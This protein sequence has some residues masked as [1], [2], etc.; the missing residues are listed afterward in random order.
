MN[1]FK[2]I[3]AY[4][5]VISISFTL[6]S[7]CKSKN[8]DEKSTTNST[9]TTQ[10][11]TSI[12]HATDYTYTPII[13][14]TE[15]NTTK[16]VHTVPPVPTYEEK[17]EKKTNNYPIQTNNKTDTTENKTPT[18]EKIEDLNK[19]LSL[20]TKTTPVK[21]GNSATIIIQGTP[22]AKYSIEFYKNSAETAEYQ[23]LDEIKA[24]STGF[25]SWTF[26]I[27]N[28]C[29]IGNRK[30]IIKEK[31]SNKFIQTSITVQ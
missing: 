30:I 28:D 6:F 13:I 8:N 16:Y 14:E 21:K 25:A 10:S 2:S 7:A 1:K 31:N 19:D 27:E 24:D 5:L 11:V 18:N 4:V 26:N 29:E 15:N 20:I 22:D 9:Q 12:I 3:S 23:G 17:N